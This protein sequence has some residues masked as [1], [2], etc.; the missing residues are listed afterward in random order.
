M[1]VLLR[2]SD[3]ATVSDIR[4]WVEEE[5]AYLGVTHSSTDW[6]SSLGGNLHWPT[7]SFHSL[8]R[9]WKLTRHFQE[10]NH[11][12]AC[13]QL[14]LATVAFAQFFRKAARRFCAVQHEP[15]KTLARTI[16]RKM[17]RI[18]GLNPVVRVYL[19][20]VNTPRPSSKLHRLSSFQVTKFFSIKTDEPKE[21][22]TYFRIAACCRLWYLDGIYSIRLSTL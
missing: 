20:Y 5:A 7:I 2:T 10:T 17:S 12:V 18:E 22:G 14:Q 19:Q 1:N 15:N 21:Y 6:C 4:C 8:D 3:L 16:D 9:I 11:I 13:T